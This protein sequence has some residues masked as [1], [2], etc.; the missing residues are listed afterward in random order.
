MNKR[1]V[2]N[3]YLVQPSDKNGGLNKEH[4]TPSETNGT[5]NC[6]G[7]LVFIVMLLYYVVSTAVI[8]GIE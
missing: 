8:Y 3:I 7:F 2:H 6:E 5:H 4:V 1:F